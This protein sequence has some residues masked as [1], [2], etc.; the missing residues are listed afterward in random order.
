MRGDRAA[1]T[2]DMH[3]CG[4]K[5]LFWDLHEDSE[6]QP[7]PFPQVVS[8]MNSCTSTASSTRGRERAERREPRQPPLE[9]GAAEPNLVAIPL[10]CPW[11]TKGGDY[12]KAQSQAY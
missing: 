7:N 12:L 8:L 4:G 11:Q 5:C 3:V 10:S 2:W 1:T 6:P 9:E